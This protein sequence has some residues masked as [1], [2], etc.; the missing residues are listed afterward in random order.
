MRVVLDTNVLVSALLSHGSAPGRVLALWRSGRFDLVSADEQIEEL[1]RVTRYPKIRSR[2]PPHLA[3]RLVNGLRDL[4]VMVEPVPPVTL[5][6]DPFDN[7]LLALAGASRAD[8]LVTGDRRDLLHLCRHAGTRI[9][10]VREFLALTGEGD[11][12]R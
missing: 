3:G 1:R 4:A 12:S 5:C 9:V 6:A 7:Y 11:L 10:A 8:F 2:L